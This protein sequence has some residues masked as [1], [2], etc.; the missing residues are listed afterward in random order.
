[1]VEEEEDAVALETSSTVQWR[2]RRN[3]GLARSG[4]MDQ[5]CG[6]LGEEEEV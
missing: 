6:T 2:C 3:E 4:R 5:V 1:L